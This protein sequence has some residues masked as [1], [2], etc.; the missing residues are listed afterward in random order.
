LNELAL[1]YGIA[2]S[3]PANLPFADCMH[4]FVPFDRSTCTLDRSESK[5]RCDPL[6][7]KPM[8]LLDDV[9]QIRRR[10]AATTATEFTGL[11]QLGDRA[12]V[13]WMPVRVDHSRPRSLASD[14]GGKT[15]A[16]R[17][18]VASCQRVSVEPFAWFKDVL[19]RIADHPITRL[20]ELLPQNWAP[21]QNKN[22]SHKCRHYKAAT[23]VDHA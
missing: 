5:A 9:V 2:L 11:L 22:S 3:E 10:S 18:F 4:R 17:S 7:D 15:A 13:G 14:Q 1:R 12:G 23:E 16:V 20:A 19:S 21:A 8:V 6:L